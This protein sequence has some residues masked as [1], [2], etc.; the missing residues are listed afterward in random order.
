MLDPLAGDITPILTP[1][2]RT[3]YDALGRDKFYCQFREGTFTTP[4]PT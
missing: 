3:A 1:A 2:E 4:K